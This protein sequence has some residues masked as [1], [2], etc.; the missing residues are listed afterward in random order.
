MIAGIASVREALQG[1]PG[2]ETCLMRYEDGGAVQAFII[3]D[4]TARVGAS[5]TVGDIRAAFLAEIAK[6]AGGGS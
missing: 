4:M 6:N 1:I 2:A 5:A 3:G